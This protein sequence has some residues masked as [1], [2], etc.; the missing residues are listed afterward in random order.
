[1]IDLG[2]WQTQVD[3]PE[4]PFGFVYCITN[5]TN[6]RKY[7]GKKQM[8]SIIKRPP[9][10]GKKRRRLCTKETDWRTYT[11]SSNQLND[12][13]KKEGMDNFK[14]EIISFHNSKSALGYYEAKLQFDLDVLL[15]ESYYN[16][17]INMRI[18]KIKL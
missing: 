12:D 1:M 8:T 3:V 4:E 16:G 6:D 13:I 17:I 9:L 11:S 14:F 10:K 18:G 5:L 7:I 2:H 15:T